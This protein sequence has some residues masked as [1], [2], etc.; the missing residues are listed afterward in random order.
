MAKADFL[1]NED[2]QYGGSRKRRGTIL[3]VNPAV[4]AAEMEKGMHPDTK[5][6]MSSLLNHCSPMNDLAKKLTEK[7]EGI[8]PF[9][10]DAGSTEEEDAAILE[11]SKLAEIEK[12][13]KEF[14]A[15]GKPY[16]PAWQGKRLKMELEKAKREAP[17]PIRQPEPKR[18]KVG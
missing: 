16:H 5:K 12:L 14:D 8:R 17:A 11:A 9:N 15:I 3:E 6:P 2:F 1:V 7:M 10:E 13:R 18:E 4:V